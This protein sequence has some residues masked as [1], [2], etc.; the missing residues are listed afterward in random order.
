MHL[1]YYTYEKEPDHWSF[2]FKS[3]GNRILTKKVEFQR[4]RSADF[5]NLALGDVDEEG[6]M[7]IY[8]VSNNG[9]MYK[10]LS[11]VIQIITFFL[12][13]NPD[14]VVFIQGSTE[15]RTRLY[16][17]AIARELHHFKECFFIA[18]YNGVTFE[19]FQRERSYTA[20]AISL[21]KG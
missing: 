8:S 14:A 16:Q 3:T 21:K 19:L 15:E 7:D 9:D 20:F 10:V 17:I 1:P 18:G 13:T 11:T 2:Y 4:L 6:K 5:Y 12:D